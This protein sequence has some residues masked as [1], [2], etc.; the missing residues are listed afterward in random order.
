MTGQPTEPTAVTALVDD[1]PITYVRP[2]PGP[3]RPS[4]ALWLPPA[5]DSNQRPRD[6]E[7]CYLVSC[8]VVSAAPA[9]G[10]A[11]E[12]PIANLTTGRAA[13]MRG[14]SRWAE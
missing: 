4:L 12:A 5:A 9:F 2:K 14:R 3:N 13:P 7:S 1:V 6:Y 11:P 8:A 10:R